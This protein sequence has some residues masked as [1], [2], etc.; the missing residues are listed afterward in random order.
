MRTAI[1]V[2]MLASPCALGQG[3]HFVGSGQFGS[4]EDDFGLATGLELL[5]PGDTFSF[6]VPVLGFDPDPEG[7]TTDATGSAQMY[8][9][10]YPPDASITFAVGATGHVHTMGLGPHGLTYEVR[11]NVT[12]ESGVRDELIIEWWPT[13]NT[14]SRHGGSIFTYSMTLSFAPDEWA[15][16]VPL[17]DLDLSRAL[18]AGG[19]LADDEGF[20]IDIPTITFFEVPAP[21]VSAVMGLGGFALLRRRG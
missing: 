17:G 18:D 4:V 13:P 3:M 12:T 2:V 21:G 11:D 20:R 14:A 1:A 8:Y 5:A 19:Y 9:A 15:G 7:F 6:D 16:V 10:P